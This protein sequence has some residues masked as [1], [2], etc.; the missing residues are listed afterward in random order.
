M[1]P[2]LA[3]VL[4]H[5]FKALTSH[6][7]EWLHPAVERLRARAKE[8]GTSGPTV[9]EAIQAMVAPQVFHDAATT[10]RSK[11]RRDARLVGLLALALAALLAGGLRLAWRRRPAMGSRRDADGEAR[12]GIAVHRRARR[13]RLRRRTRPR[14]RLRGLHA[15]RGELLVARFGVRCTDPSPA[16]PGR[17]AAVTCEPVDAQR[18]QCRAPLDAFLCASTWDTRATPMCGL[19]VYSLDRALLGGCGAQSPC[20]N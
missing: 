8:A 10:I 3:A 6:H 16:G 11:A 19:R 7:G 12:T 15:P 13:R 1:P 4:R 2:Q 20:R 14:R 5:E 18:G 9:Q 17:D